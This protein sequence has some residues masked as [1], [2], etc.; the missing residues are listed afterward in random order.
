VLQR[1][2][3]G[4]RRVS[5][6]LFHRDFKRFQGGHLKVFHYFQHVRASRSHR[7][8]IRFSPDSVWDPSNPW[9]A[10]RDTLADTQG[11]D[12]DVLFLAGQDWRFL[13]LPERVSSPLPVINMIQ[14]FRHTRPDEGLLE[15]RAIRIC[16]SAELQQELECTRGVNGPIFTVPIALDLDGLPAPLPFAERDIECLILAV[17]EPPTGRALADRLRAEGQR[18]VLLDGPAPRAQLLRA[19]ARA[20]VTVHLPLRREGAYLPAL[21]SMALGSLVVCPDCVGNRSFCRDGETCLVPARR[22]RAIAERA[23]LALT[24][25]QPEL[26]PILD[27]A[28]R[29]V[30][31]RGLAGER[32]RFLEILDRAAELWE[33][34]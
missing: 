17:K 24:A 2:A 3:I 32:A 33:G 9:F 16:V 5:T 19:M 29:E 27:G 28:R 13:T 12:P 23:L 10:L 1:Q 18:V 26:Q 4:A 6:V 20:R 31:G 22:E 7:A 34:G 15:Y 25:S 11:A 8:L 21:E 14:G 30:A